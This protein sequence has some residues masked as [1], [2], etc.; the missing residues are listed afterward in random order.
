MHKNWQEINMQEKK[1]KQHAGEKEMW[2]A[3]RQA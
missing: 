2:H 3:I 1:E